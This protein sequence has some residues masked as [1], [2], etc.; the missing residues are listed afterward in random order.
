MRE[1]G[2]ALLAVVGFFVPVWLVAWV[3]GA[4]GDPTWLLVLVPYAAAWLWAIRV[5]GKDDYVDE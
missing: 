4:Y 1:F 2:W 5:V 3:A